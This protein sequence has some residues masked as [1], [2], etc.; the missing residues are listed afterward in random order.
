MPVT[1]GMPASAAYATPC[2]IAISPT[3]SPAIAS[4]RSSAASGRGQ[5]RKGNRRCRVGMPQC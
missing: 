5:A 2:G 4:P 3:V 1:S